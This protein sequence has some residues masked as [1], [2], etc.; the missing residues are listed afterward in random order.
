MVVLL[1]DMR[2]H[3]FVLVFFVGA[4]LV[5]LLLWSCFVV[6]S[7]SAGVLTAT[8]GGVIHYLN[9]QRSTLVAESTGAVSEARGCC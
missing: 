1:E 2:E 9:I 5:L 3:Y 7:N 8:T 6:V 4:G